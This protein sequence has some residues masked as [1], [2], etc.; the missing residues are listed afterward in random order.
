MKIIIKNSDQSV[1]TVGDF[2]DS[3]NPQPDT[4]YTIYNI[5]GWDWS[6]A[7]LTGVDMTPGGPRK[8]LDQLKWNGVTLVKK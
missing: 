6:L 4:D 1:F 5:P 7:D 8:L 3:G 2:P